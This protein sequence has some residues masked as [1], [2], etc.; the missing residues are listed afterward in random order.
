MNY[1]LIILL[2]AVS[3]FFSAAESAYSSL[4][5]LRLRRAA[6]GKKGAVAWAWAVYSDYQNALIAMLIGNNLANIA[7]ASIATTIALRLLGESYAWVA[8]VLMTLLILTF[9][10]ILPKI[11]AGVAPHRVAVFA[12]APMRA[13]MLLLFPI[14][15]LLTR[16]LAVL[17]RLWQKGEQPPTMTEGELETIL[18]T[19]EDEGVLDE[20]AAE[21]VQSALDF[22]DVLCYEILTPR[23]DMVA[24]DMEHTREELLRIAFASPYTRL[25]CYAGTPDH[26]VGI[27]HLNHL[28]KK[29][30]T[31]PE[32]DIAS[33]LMSAVYVHKTTPLP[34]VLAQMRAQNC[35]MVIVTD[36]YGGTMGILTMEDI[37]EQLVGDIWDESDE[38]ISEFVQVGEHAYEAD[39]DMRLADFLEEFDKD[40][41]D[42]HDDNA[43][44][45]GWAVQQLGGYPKLHETFDFENL[46]ITIIKRSKLRVTRL[47]VEVDGDNDNSQ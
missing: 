37:L 36:E 34:D 47:R 14:T 7:S 11:M 17:A 24:L 38:I 15:R 10:E 19:V 27:L 39:G 3:A 41:E 5:P 13:L 12:A 45:G 44:V 23:V 4:N 29:L 28:Y 42:L 1:I 26:I 16:L 21:L 40:A 8:T 32:T 9:G 20:E 43:T 33:L 35:H 6:A 25:P 22:D 31:E 46:S 30:V 2:I 18:E